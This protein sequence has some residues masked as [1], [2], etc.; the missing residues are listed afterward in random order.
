MVIRLT[1]IPEKG[2][3]VAAL[4]D[5]FFQSSSRTSF[6][7]AAERTAF[8]ARWT[9][10]Y[11]DHCPDDVLLWREAD[12]SITGYLTGCRDSA[13]AI[14][15][16]DGLPGYTVFADCFA[17]FPAHLHVNCRPDRRGRG[18][19]AALIEAFAS[20][21]AGAGLAGLHI[22]TAPSARNVQFYAR[23][24]FDHRVDRAWAGHPLLFMGRR[25]HQGP[26][27]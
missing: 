15:L 1:D 26:Q 9:A 23:A 11:L 25:L 2:P 6:A 4:T 3:A 18:I 22:V 7:T 13:G 10:Y 27:A 19:G 14:P 21:C 17:A 5:I 24:G 20:D 12:G 8:L 16:H